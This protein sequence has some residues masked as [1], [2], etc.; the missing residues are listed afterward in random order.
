MFAAGAKYGPAKVWPA[1]SY[2][3]LALRLRDETGLRPV[4]VG[5]PDERVCLETISSKTDGLNL[6]GKSGVGELMSVLRG[7]DLVV[8]N[9][10]GPVHVSAAMGVP[11]VAIFGSTSPVWTSPGGE[12]AL[13]VSSGAVCSPCFRKECPEGD[14]HCLTD[15]GIDEVFEASMKLM[16]ENPK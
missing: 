10:S 6:S 3:G 7:A 13:T 4:L 8:G 9:D 16:G 11:T 15:I 5:S 12:R 14:T 2:V 1:D